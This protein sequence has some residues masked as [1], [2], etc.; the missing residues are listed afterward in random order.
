MILLSILFF[1]FAGPA[2]PQSKPAAADQLASVKKLYDAQQWQEVVRATS[3]SPGEP[4]DLELYR[5]LA[6]AQLGQF[7]HARQTF[8]N[9]HRQNP[10]DPRFL[11]ELAGLAYR[12]KRYSQAKIDLRRALSLQPQDDYSNDFLASIYFLEGNLE[13]ALKYWNRVGKPRL[14][15]LTYSPAPHLD[16][17]ILDRAFRFSPGGVWRRNQYLT[18]QAQLVSLNLFP[19][20]FDELQAQP[21][22]SFNLVFHASQRSRW[23]DSKLE[24]LVSALRSLPYQAVDPEFFN[25]NNK[26]LNW[27]SFVRWDAQKRMLDSELAAPLP[28]GPSRR[29]RLYF[30]GRNE[31]WNI[32]RTLLPA[33][34]APAGL[35]MER[36]AIGAEIQSLM[37]WRWQWD[38]GA[39]FSDRR[40][41][42][43]FGI[44]AA[45]APFFTGSPGLALRAGV[46]SSLLRFPERR[47]TLNGGAT[48]EAGKFFT[49]PLG[50]YA[51]AE[52]SLAADW[53]P[54]ATDDDYQTRTRLR[55]GRTFG[56]IPF[57]DLYMLGFDRDNPLWMR[58]HNGLVNGQ[59]GNAPLGR[60]FVLSNS[61]FDKVAFH[62]ALLELQLGPFLDT[63][64][65]YD[66]S[67]Y[68]G[69]PKWLVD[70]GVQATVRALGSFEVVLGYGRD[71]RS[72]NNTFYSTVS[73]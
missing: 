56:Q 66:P 55:A 38:L 8:R 29:F 16:P 4:A 30:D 65:I 64:N 57:D 50:R 28:S 49:S 17:L 31:N 32:A 53:L 68:F 9:G 67:A 54:Q 41:R 3:D 21:D 35:N 48:A 13:A 43:L 59:K 5:G 34:P 15:D 69:S 45:A 33:H 61:D 27:V 25:L 40:F 7:D 51:R 18:T 12:D 71:L 37:G 11:V 60:N 47:F 39:E 44:P 20:M 63:G 52:G 42:S 36:A 58:G 24:S 46:Q 1:L 6:L 19:S 26:G 2:S 23:R 22:G 72:G 70:S 73:R 10:R 62:D 14:K